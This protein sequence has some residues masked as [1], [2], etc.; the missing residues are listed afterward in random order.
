MLE[1]LIELQLLSRTFLI[2]SS[3]KDLS[4]LKVDG[5]LLM[6]QIVSFSNSSFITGV[7]DAIFLLQTLCDAK[8][9]LKISEKR[10]FR[11]MTF[12]LALNVFND[13]NP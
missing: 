8:L 6:C 10:R 5:S 12:Q 2:A 11:K 9:N 1:K 4:H 3:Q 13:Q 7:K